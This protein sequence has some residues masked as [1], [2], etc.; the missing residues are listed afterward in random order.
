MAVLNITNPT[1]QE[2]IFVFRAP[3]QR[4]NQRH[5]IPS[6][7]TV[8]VF[9]G[10]VD[11]CEAIVRQHEV[12]GMKKFTHALSKRSEHA[13]GLLY[14]IDKDEMTRDSAAITQLRKDNNELLDDIAAAERARQ[15]VGVAAANTR[16]RTE[17]TSLEVS[18]T[19]EADANNRNAELIQTVQV[20]RKPGRPPKG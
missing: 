2:W 14:S 9:S 8:A 5:D 6:G 1:F 3:E 20:S 4:H 18:V 19:R 10:A 15:A 7:S 17:E 16:E 12:Y 11:E 13:I